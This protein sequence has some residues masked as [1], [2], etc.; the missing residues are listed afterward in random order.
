MIPAMMPRSQQDLDALKGHHSLCP[1]RHMLLVAQCATISTVDLVKIDSCSSPGKHRT[2]VYTGDQMAQEVLEDGQP[3]ITFSNS[4]AFMKL[5][6][7]G[8]AYSC[9]RSVGRD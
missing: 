1:L 3:T 4:P 9:G 8:S 2:T 7:V 6:S 5:H